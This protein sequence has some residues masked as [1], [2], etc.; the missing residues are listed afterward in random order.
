[1]LASAYLPCLNTRLK[2]VEKSNLGDIVLQFSHIHTSFLGARVAVMMG[3]GL[4]FSNIVQL[5]PEPS[6]SCSHSLSA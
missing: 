2:C 5:P 6:H 1:M 3:A 4:F